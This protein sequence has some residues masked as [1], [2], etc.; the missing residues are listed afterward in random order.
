MRGAQTCYLC[1]HARVHAIQQRCS[2]SGRG[3]PGTPRQGHDELTKGND[4]GLLRAGRHRLRI[5]FVPVRSDQVLS[6]AR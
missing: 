2:R 5:G 6:D 4:S 1:D 3:V